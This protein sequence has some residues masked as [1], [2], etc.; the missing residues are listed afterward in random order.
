MEMSMVLVSV[1]SSIAI[2]SAGLAVSSL[3]TLQTR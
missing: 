2:L 3:F 1:L